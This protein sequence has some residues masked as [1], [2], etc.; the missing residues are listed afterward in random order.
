MTVAS[1]KDE[2]VHIF[3]STVHSSPGRTNILMSLPLSPPN[4]LVCVM[5]PHASPSLRNILDVDADVDDGDGV[6]GRVELGVVHGNADAVAL[7]AKFAAGG[8]GF[9]H[10]IPTKGLVKE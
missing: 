8:G 9:I 6:V 2:Y 7:G 5:P 1:F 4:E 10:E 3:V